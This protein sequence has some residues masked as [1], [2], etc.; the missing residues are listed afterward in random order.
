MKYTRLTREERHT[1]EILSRQGLGVRE[2]A[3]QMG[4]AG[5]TISRELSRNTTQGEEYSSIDAHRLSRANHHGAKPKYN[6]DV[7][8]DVESRVKE[9][10]SP[11]QIT[12]FFRKAEKPV[13]SHEWIYQYLL[14]DKA[15]GGSLYTHLRH[16]L[17]SYR[18]RGAGKERRG[19]IKDQRMIEERPTV[20]ELKNR[21]GDWEI[22][23]MIGLQGGAV[24]V[25]LV[26]RM[27]RYTLI[28]KA[29]SKEAMAVGEQLWRALRL[30]TDKVLTITADNGKEFA[31]HKLTAALLECDYYFANPYASWERGLNENT[32]GS[33]GSTSPKKATSITSQKMRF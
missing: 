18:K 23:T 29:E 13:P 5:S 26:D 28:R 3:S 27:S 9:G 33:S 22:D 12:G 16:P 1:I 7:W 17:K 15:E 4:R 10:W 21:V 31:G 25:T 2:I 19:R 11:E 24:L 30:H 6:A 8:N 14:T 32:N 20:V